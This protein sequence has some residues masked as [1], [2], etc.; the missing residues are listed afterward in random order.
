MTTLAEV[1]IT[2]AVL[3]VGPNVGDIHIHDVLPTQRACNFA[4][5]ALQHAYYNGMARV[6]CHRTLLPLSILPAA[7][8]SRPNASDQITLHLTTPAQNERLDAL[9]GVDFYPPITD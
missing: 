1:F 7:L 6:E 9:A 3:T 2:V 5:H 8:T 4:K